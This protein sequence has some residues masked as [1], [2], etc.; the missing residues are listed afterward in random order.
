MTNKARR[1]AHVARLL[2]LAVAATLVIPTAARA[3]HNSSGCDDTYVCLFQHR[4]FNHNDSS[5]SVKQFRQCNVS[6]DS[7][8]DWQDLADFGFNDQM[9][10]W[11]SKRI[12]DA[13]WAWNS[14]GSGTRRCIESLSSTSYV[15]DGDNDEASA[16]KI[17]DRD[18]VC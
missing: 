17:F 10:S 15:G 1:R 11:Y 13:K 9:S 12:Y 2:L 3:E 16:I 5:G 8:C 14:D 18:D 6:G 4:D 7:N